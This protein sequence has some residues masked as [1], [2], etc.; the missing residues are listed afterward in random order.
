MKRGSGALENGRSRRPRCSRYITRASRQERPAPADDRA[1][2][3]RRGGCARLTPL[4]EAH[5]ACAEL[6]GS[7]WGREL[8]DAGHDGRDGLVV[9]HEPHVDFGRPRGQH[10]DRRLDLETASSITDLSPNLAALHPHDAGH[11]LFL[12][13]PRKDLHDGIS[14]QRQVSA[15]VDLDE[16]LALALH[17]QGIALE[18]ADRSASA[19]TGLHAVGPHHDEHPDGVPGRPRRDRL[20]ESRRRREG[21]ERK[22]DQRDA[23]RRARHFDTTTRIGF[24]PTG[25]VAMTWLVPVSI[26]CRSFE[27]SCTTNSRVPWGLAA[28]PFGA[29][30]T[31]ISS[32]SRKRLASA[33]R[34]RTL[35][36]PATVT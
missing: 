20:R 2:V 12:F 3:R 22:G 11:A 36:N 31:S 8:A 30:P 14:V 18:D 19:Q 10:A 7:K 32:S 26:T 1:D 33:S 28:I 5:G 34:T 4:T 35:L 29:S 13:P 15:L 6:A 27:R 21:E 24:R 17:L 16:R 25:T 23:A 9:G